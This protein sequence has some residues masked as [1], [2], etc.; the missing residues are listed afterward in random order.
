VESARIQF[1]G[2][3]HALAHARPIA[4]EAAYHRNERAFVVDFAK[5]HVHRQ[6][7]ATALA[8]LER[9]SRLANAPAKVLH[10]IAFAGKTRAG[11][12]PK[13][14]CAGQVRRDLPLQLAAIGLP[15]LIFVSRQQGA[16]LNGQR[17]PAIGAAGGQ[18]IEGTLLN[19]EPAGASGRQP[20]QKQFQAELLLVD[21]H[22]R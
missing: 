15:H 7:Q 10:G 6:T 14:E 3:A 19:M 8:R 11:R 13:R 1:E 12:H 9:Q 21:R 18:P 22:L 17:A 5:A 20:V 16:H 2:A 4:A